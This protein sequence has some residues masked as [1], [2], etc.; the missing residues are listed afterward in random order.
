MVTAK[1]RLTK[2]LARLVKEP[3]PLIRAKPL[4]NDILTWHYLLEGTPGS[5]YEGGGLAAAA[6]AALRRRADVPPNHASRRL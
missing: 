6:A 4:D 1:A 5:P 3:P 2:E